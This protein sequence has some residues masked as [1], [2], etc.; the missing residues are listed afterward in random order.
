[1]SAQAQLGY[2]TW[3]NV[4]EDHSKTYRYAY[5]EVPTNGSIVADGEGTL[6]A[7][8]GTDSNMGTG[9]NNNS[10]IRRCVWNAALNYDK[11]FSEK[12]HVYGQL[13]YD[14][15]YNDKTGTNTTVYRHNISLFGHYGYD[16]RLLFDV[17]LVES[18]S[19]RMAPGDKWAMSPNVSF[20]WNISNESL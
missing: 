18:G 1:M 19:S 9:A 14:Y 13:K 8:Q 12:H 7:V 4:Y 5:Y 3:S 10:W 2:D 17:A 11:N 15:E 16:N 20:A 6:S